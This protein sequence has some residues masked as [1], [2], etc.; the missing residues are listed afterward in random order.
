MAQARATDRCFGR[1]GWENQVRAVLRWTCLSR[2][3]GGEGYEQS[4][5]AFAGPGGQAGDQIITSTE[6]SVIGWYELSPTAGEGAE[7]L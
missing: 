2:V 7:P 5:G 6:E 1:S 3:L 4:P